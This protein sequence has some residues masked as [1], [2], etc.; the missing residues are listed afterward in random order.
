MFGRLFQKRAISR[1]AVS[2]AAPLPGRQGLAI[3]LIV[4]NEERHIG[5]WVRFHLAAGVRAVFAYDNGSTDNTVQVLQDCGGDRVTVTPWQQKLH[6]AATGREIHNQVLA[7]AHAITNFGGTFRWMAAI[8]ADEFLVPKTA[9]SL[10]GAL[11]HLGAEVGA[12]TLPWHNFGRNG[13]TVAPA[14]G[15]L[16][17][18]TQ[19][20]SDPMSG[21]RGATALLL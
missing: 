18:Y 10:D 12:V 21:A 19:R 7:Y 17:N 11:G 13:H 15:V 20:A 14:G 4:R 6:D 8:D 1:I 9:A 16:E 3:A 2:A 5:E